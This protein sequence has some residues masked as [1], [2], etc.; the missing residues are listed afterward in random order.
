MVTEGHIK[1]HA[2]RPF[3]ASFV[4]IDASLCHGQRLCHGQP[5][6]SRRPAK[7]VERN[8]SP[9]HR[10]CRACSPGAVAR[11]PRSCSTSIGGVLRRRAI[12]RRRLRTAFSSSPKACVPAL[13]PTPATGARNR[14]H[15]LQNRSSPRKRQSSAIRKRHRKT[16]CRC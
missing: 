12:R 2:P 3:A 13:H 11:R 10:A 1:R 6:P 15:C 14:P 9:N 7:W 16:R 5:T 4:P 8:T